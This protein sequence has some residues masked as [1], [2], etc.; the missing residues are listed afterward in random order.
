VGLLNDIQKALKLGVLP[1]QIWDDFKKLHPDYKKARELGISDEQIYRDLGLPAKEI[2]QPTP[3]VTPEVKPEFEPAPAVTTGVRTAKMLPEFRGVGGEESKIKDTWDAFYVG[4]RG[5]WHRSKQYFLSVLPNQI[6]PDIPMPKEVTPKTKVWAENIKKSNEW[7]RKLRNTFRE[8]YNKADKQYKKWIKEHPE[9]K[10]RKEYEGSVIENVK[11]NPKLLLDPGYW[12]Y[13]AAESAAFTMGVMGTTLAVTALTKNPFLGMTAGVAVATPMQS[14]DLYED[15]IENGATEEQASQLATV[16]GP[17]IASVEVAGDLP[18]L[19]A[20]S[21]PFSRLLTRNIHREVAKRTMKSLAKKGLKTFTAIEIGET[22]EE[23]TQGAIQD[24]TVKTIN[25]NRSVL[26]NIPETTVRTLMATVPF[27]LAGVGGEAVRGIERRVKLPVAETIPEEVKPEPKPELK[28]EVKPE[29]KPEIKKR[30]PKAL[31]IDRVVLE[32]QKKTEGAK[33][34]YDD[35]IKSWIKTQVGAKFA[36]GT[37]TETQRTALEKKAYNI[38]QKY[39]PEYNREKGHFKDFVRKPIN[40][41][42]RGEKVKVKPEVKPE[43]VL[44]IERALGFKI[45]PTTHEEKEGALKLAIEAVKKMNNWAGELKVMGTFV[46]KTDKPYSDID[47]MVTTDN[48]LKP[49]AAFTFE[50]IEKDILSKTGIFVDFSHQG[51][52]IGKTKRVLVKQTES[53]ITIRP[54]IKPEMVVKKPTKLTTMSNEELAKTIVINKDLRKEATTQIITKNEPL[55]NKLSW[56][57]LK[58]NIG[59]GAFEHIKPEDVD[60]TDLQKDLISAVK[61]DM[62]KLDT[63]QKYAVKKGKV[64]TYIGNIVLKEGVKMLRKSFPKVIKKVT[65]EEM[66]R[67][68]A[69]EEL[70]SKV[71]ERA[72]EQKVL[73]E[74]MSEFRNLLSP[75]EKKILTEL[76]TEPHAIQPIVTKL[77]VKPTDIRR[78]KRQLH[79]FA[80]E[81]KLQYMYGGIPLMPLNPELITEFKDLFGI[82]AKEL[83]KLIDVN[84]L[85]RIDKLTP[86]EVTTLI[87]NMQTKMERE[88]KE[89]RLGR[90]K[91]YP[92]KMNLKPITDKQVK[93]IH[94]IATAKGLTKIKY[95]RAL[96]R[97]AHDF[98]GIEVESSK[99]LNITQANI[100][101]EYLRKLYDRGGKVKIP[102]KYQIALRQVIEQGGFLARHPVLRHTWLVQYFMPRMTYFDSV[103]AKHL[104]KKLEYADIDK[105]KEIHKWFIDVRKQFKNIKTGG[106]VDYAIFYATENMNREGVLKPEAEGILRDAIKTEKLYQR[107]IDIAKWLRGNYARFIDTI[108]E[109]RVTLKLKPIKEKEYYSPH[110]VEEKIL[111]TIRE[112]PQS[113][114]LEKQWEAISDYILP[115]KTAMRF[116]KPRKGQ[117]PY[118]KSAIKAFRAYVVGYAN[119]KHMAI[120]LMI[121]RKELSLYDPDIQN[122]IKEFM[123]DLFPR[124]GWTDMVAG[125]IIHMATID[126][127]VLL[128]AK[129]FIQSLQGM[130]MTGEKGFGEAIIKWHTS[131]MRAL[132]KTNPLIVNRSPFEVRQAETLLRNVDKLM[133]VLRVGNIPYRVADYFNISSSYS[134]QVITSLKQYAKETGQ[135]YNTLFK[136]YIKFA[137]EASLADPFK[138]IPNPT[139]NQFQFETIRSIAYQVGA[140]SQ[141]LYKTHDMPKIFAI[142]GIRT[143]FALTSWGLNWSFGYAPTQLKRMITGVGFEGERLTPNQRIGFIKFLLFTILCGVTAWKA[144]K[145]RR[146][147]TNLLYGIGG[148][149][150]PFLGI[151][152]IMNLMIS[153]VN[154]MGAYA[155]PYASDY[156]RKQAWRKFKYS[157]KSLMP[158]RTFIKRMGSETLMGKFFGEA[159]SSKRKSLTPP[160]PIMRR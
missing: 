120:P 151:P 80:V 15:L 44:R 59:Y 57:Y 92:K 93:R 89:G 110:I 45:K 62:L 119:I 150:I 79:K 154:L 73:K 111:E 91:I 37:I 100:F 160:R 67:I 105:K 78:V 76:Y 142:P 99:E 28:P 55:L 135:S 107:V 156:I 147:L 12:G 31:P 149:A 25:K 35:K 86:E 61:G 56:D 17:I 128:V 68:P 127:N 75:I 53:P 138:N 41:M 63:W 71:V 29:L 47:V 24:A 18:F 14:Q 129:N 82:T 64:N 132:R 23:I 54:A 39:I 70:P 159:P 81:N 98:Y 32:V 115:T 43:K 102:R 33:E 40:V 113:E 7:R 134:N 148:G 66:E 109:I 124:R 49:D 77:G 145:E 4:S 20:V 69:K 131:D 51:I 118:Q 58:K 83:E 48:Y 72:E 90:Y 126:A 114:I 42:L 84:Q 130:M 140:T 30:L 94:A 26:A 88:A 117:L 21:K 34:L 155:S 104:W 106:N 116:L 144:K 22:L 9:L 19:R 96:K 52:P 10:P 50:K 5:M 74:K 95:K 139:R 143:M 158:W 36:K 137:S 46:T 123:R 152:F 122:S 16:I 65:E 153:T 133:K 141:Y 157:I 60:M 97:F 1:E 87:K 136:E 146:W 3:K 101:A 38:A 8:K 125:N 2:I 121:T 13:I 112:M 108:N 85:G 27:A 6:L 11:K 103:G